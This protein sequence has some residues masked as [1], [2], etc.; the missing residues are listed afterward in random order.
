MSDA[1]LIRGQYVYTC[2]A[3]TTRLLAGSEAIAALR[4]DLQCAH[5]DY[6]HCAGAY[7]RAGTPLARYEISEELTRIAQHA[8]AI[9]RAIAYL[10]AVN[11]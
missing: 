10:E 5:G 1:I 2:P 7:F 11:V 6:D 8:A 4:C 9:R 3:G